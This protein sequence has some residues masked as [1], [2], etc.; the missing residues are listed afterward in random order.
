MVLC[1]SVVPGYPLFLAL[2]GVT[3]ESNLACTVCGKRLASFWK[4]SFRVVGYEYFELKLRTYMTNVIALTLL[5]LASQ[6]VA[7]FAGEP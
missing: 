5:A 2:T 1:A 4:R 3:S 6:A 7:T